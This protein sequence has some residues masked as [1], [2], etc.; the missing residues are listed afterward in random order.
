MKKKSTLTAFWSMYN[1]HQTVPEE[2]V[3]SNFHIL[4]LGVWLYLIIQPSVCKVHAVSQVAKAVWTQAHG[5]LPGRP[6]YCEAGSSWIT[7]LWQVTINTH[8][9][10][11]YIFGC[12]PALQ[13]LSHLSSPHTTS[14]TADTKPESQLYISLRKPLQ[15]KPQSWY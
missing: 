1:Y 4:N 9:T 11:C 12:E 15:C 8:A 2:N 5:A 10:F 13:W 3:P 7:R 14:Q 6:V